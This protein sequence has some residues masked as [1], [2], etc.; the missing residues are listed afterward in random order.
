MK[1]ICYCS[2]TDSIGSIETRIFQT[3]EFVGYLAGYWRVEVMTPVR[4]FLWPEKAAV[5]DDFGNLVAV[6]V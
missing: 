6:E 1:S 3:R 2:A 4:G 5:V